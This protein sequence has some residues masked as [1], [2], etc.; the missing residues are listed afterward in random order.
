MLD[1]KEEKSDTEKK[2]IVW[3]KLISLY[4][5]QTILLVFRYEHFIVNVTGEKPHV[6][7]QWR[8]DLE[9]MSS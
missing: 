2:H 6:I 4:I 9:M 1:L 3:I 5:W 8:W 7:V